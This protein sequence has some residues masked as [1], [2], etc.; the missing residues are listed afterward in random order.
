MNSIHWRKRII[1]SKNR[2]SSKLKRTIDIQ[3]TV[4]ATN[5]VNAILKTNSIIKEK[6]L[7]CVPKRSS[8]P[9]R[10]EPYYE[11]IDK[12]FQDNATV[13]SIFKMMDMYP[14]ITINVMRRL[15]LERYSIIK[16]LLTNNP[17]LEHGI[18]DLVD[19]NLDID[20]NCMDI[21]LEYNSTKMKFIHKSCVT[22]I[23][24][25]YILNN[26]N[27]FCKSIKYSLDDLLKKIDTCLNDC[28]VIFWNVVSKYDTDPVFLQCIASLIKNKSRKFCKY[29]IDFLNT[30]T[31]SIKCNALEHFQ[32]DSITKEKLIDTTNLC[33]FDTT[34]PDNKV[35]TS[36]AIDICFPENRRF[37]RETYIESYNITGF[38]DFDQDTLVTILTDYTGGMVK[39]NHEFCFNVLA[40]KLYTFEFNQTEVQ[41]VVTNDTL[42]LSLSV[43]HSVLF[44]EYSVP[45]M[46]IIG[47]RGLS[48]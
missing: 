11:Y 42:P 9:P 25:Q 15:S 24:T 20:P 32:I 33:S 28:S 22:F 1:N 43:Y 17:G 4:N 38:N 27:N 23:Q 39:K 30:Y 36:F 2:L 7:V 47:T 10:Y 13:N 34:I 31:C 35:V 8:L 40:G 21:L 6:Q 48:F 16:T 45:K 37:L 3:N 5:T 41:L 44:E 19:N 29:V 14:E 26:F 12:T 18:M 46:Q